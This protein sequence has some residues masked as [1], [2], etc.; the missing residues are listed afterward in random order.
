MPWR[1]V[2]TV[3]LRHEFVLLAQQ[4]DSNISALC[5][6][7]GISRK[8]AYKWLNRFQMLG[9]AGLCNKS[10]RP[11]SSPF[12]SEKTV[13][14]E[15]VALRNLHPAWGGRKLKTRLENLGHH[16]VPA[17]STITAILHRRGLI[18]PAEAAKHTAFTRFE[19]PYP[20]SL[21]QMD[22]KGH[23][24]MQQGRCHPLTVVDDHS[25]FNVVLQA[26][27]NERTDTVQT[28]LINSFRRYGLPD[29]MTMDNGSP[30]GGDGQ[31]D[32]THLT[33]WLI[34]L[35]I[36]VSHSRPYHP[37]TQGK[38]E[39]FHRTLNLEVISRRSFYDL[40]DCQRGFD[41]FRAS[42][43]MERPHESLAME[44][45]VTRY[46][47]SQRPY[48]EFLPAIEYYPGDHVRKV[49]AKGEIFFNGNVFRVSKALHGYPVAVRQTND[50]GIYS[51]YFCHHKVKDID[52]KSVTHLPEHL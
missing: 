10:R 32:L 47:V 46:K 42:Y 41:E 20:N 26:C 7:F 3:T 27:A 48:P 50:D 29:R 33:A 45:P 25:R 14:D 9:D 40:K 35:G 37:Q 15:V 5:K 18:D 19:H 52:L 30:W 13:E 39:R 6:L 34:R 28:A 36:G 44:T 22:F 17:P 1:E 31:H 24:P 38:D 16:N 23:F 21:W 2:D 11:L 12:K 4:D 8:T 43:N 51:V 49:Q